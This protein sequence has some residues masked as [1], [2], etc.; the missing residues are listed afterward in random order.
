MKKLLV[1]LI[2]LLLSHLAASA[3]MREE[4][5]FDRISSVAS[6]CLKTDD[7]GIESSGPGYKV[8][9]MLEQPVLWFSSLLF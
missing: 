1:A 7:C 4:A 8:A 2:S 5:I 6:V 9:L 3:D